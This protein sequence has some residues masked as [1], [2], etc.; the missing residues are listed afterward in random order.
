MNTFQP[1]TVGLIDYSQNRNWFLVWGLVFMALG[2]LAMTLSVFTTLLSVIFIGALFLIGGI[3]SIIDTFQFWRGQ[4]KGFY[5]HLI[6]SLLYIALGFLFIMSPAAAAISI[7]L[8]LSVFFI[9]MG[10]FRIVL[11][12]RLKSPH[13]GWIFFSGLI[14][15]ILG[16]LILAQLPA[17]GLFIIGLFIGVDLFLWGW[18][19]LMIAATKKA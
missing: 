10:L 9:V 18:S 13:W 17:S 6:M 1:M 14:T 16:L 12:F 7:T 5:T 15:F 8:F 4:S 3:A 11:S 19:Y 2:V